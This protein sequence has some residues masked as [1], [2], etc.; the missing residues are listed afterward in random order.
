MTNKKQ[1]IKGQNKMK[2][3]KD[4]TK[5]T[6]KQ[7]EYCIKHLAKLGK[8]EILKRQKII[9]AQLEIAAEKHMIEAIANLCVMSS[10][11]EFAMGNN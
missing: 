1:N 2:L 8:K 3:K 11:C 9:D 7:T 5:L 6:A 10:H 4:L